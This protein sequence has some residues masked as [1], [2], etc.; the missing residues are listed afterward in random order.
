MSDKVVRLETQFVHNATNNSKAAVNVLDE[1]QT[2]IALSE[3]NSP[4][5]L[6]Q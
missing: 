4:F 2:G 5:L 1:V 6:R 3:G